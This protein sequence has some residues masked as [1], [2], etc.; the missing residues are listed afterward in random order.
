MAAGVFAAKVKTIKCDIGGIV[1][2]QTDNGFYYAT[3]YPPIDNNAIIL[4]I[5]A[6]TWSGNVSFFAQS[7]NSVVIISPIAYT[8]PANRYIFVTYMV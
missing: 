4:N 3:Y 1:L 2:D 5:G 6:G 8:L 7:L